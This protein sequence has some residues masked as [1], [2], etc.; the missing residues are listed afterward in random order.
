M[1]N[2]KD[3]PVQWAL[4]L[5]ELDEAR[6]H[7]DRLIAALTAESEYDDSRLRVDL[8]HVM[9]HLNRAWARRNIPRDLTD[10]EWES[11]REYPKDLQPIA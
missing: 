7:L 8:G 5:D 10:E 4:W 11:F 9:A 2:S 1:I 3:N 6:E